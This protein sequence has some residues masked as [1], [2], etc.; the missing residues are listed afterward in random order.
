MKSYLIDTYV[1][2][3]DVSEQT[4][5]YSKELQDCITDFADQ[6]GLPVTLL[7]VEATETTQGGKPVTII[8]ANLITS[9]FTLTQ[10]DKFRKMEIN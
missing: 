3:G 1:K 8:Q 4:A 2:E 7:T 5:F 9:E 10:L 6:N